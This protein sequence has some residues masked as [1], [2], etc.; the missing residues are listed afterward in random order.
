MP[1]WPWVVGGTLL[2]LVVGVGGLG[3]CLLLWQAGRNPPPP[4]AATVAPPPFP[5]LVPPPVPPPAP[6]PAN[7]VPV[8]PAAWLAEGPPD[9]FPRPGPE[10]DRPRQ[11]LRDWLRQNFGGAYEKCGRKDPRWDAEARR[12][13]AAAEDYA[14]R[15]Y[16]RKDEE[17]VTWEA[18]ARAVTAGCDDPLVLYLR[19]RRSFPF[20]PMAHAERSRL[21]R[22]AAEAM[23]ESTYPPARRAYTLL[24][25]ALQPTA[26]RNNPPDPQEVRRGLDECC[27]LIPE[28]LKDPSPLAREEAID[29]FQ[30]AL[31]G[32]H[33][34]DQDRRV[35]YRRVAAVLDQAGVPESFRLLAR[36]Q[37]YTAYAWDAR[38]SG[39]ADTVSEQGWRLFGERLREA[40]AALKRSW[41]LDHTDALA[42][43][44]MLTVARGLGHPRPDMEVWFRRA[45][46]V[47]P[48]CVE[49]C[50]A[51]LTYLE[52]KWGG[53]EEA[54][55]AFGRECA[56]T[57]N[58][59]AGLPFVLVQAHRALS[60]YRPDHAAYYRR[61]PAVWQDVRGVYDAYLEAD[62]GSRYDRTWY[63]RNAYA[64]GRYREAHRQFQQVG[65]RYWR[66]AFVSD[67]EYRQMRATCARAAGAE[68]KPG[69]GGPGEAGRGAGRAGEGG[70]DD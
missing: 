34:L 49:A 11:A 20:E 59:E 9:W 35:S 53:S 13:L 63:A 36:G 1:V 16:R 21:F 64:C 40:E 69:G 70:A 45:L 60:G 25:A 32:Y 55:L 54:V 10:R 39:F 23:R 62:P 58:Q 48:D 29:L 42:A 37:F 33:K 61:D 57:R 14:L 3:A 31:A 17:Q 66:P 56:R 7:A 67:E 27:A 28:V 5:P 52:P 43:T 19:V 47:D 41:E 38:G 65:A 46:S 6:P 12:A 4:V 26:D 50:T 2:L 22:E 8:G 68:K 44:R 24:H 18:A 51:K 30:A 15:R